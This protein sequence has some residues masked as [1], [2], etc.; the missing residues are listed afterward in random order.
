M[1][2]FASSSAGIGNIFFPVYAGK[3]SGV[4]R[5]VHS[6]HS[7]QDSFSVIRNR[8]NAAGAE[9]LDRTV[10]A[11]IFVFHRP[12][13]RCVSKFLGKKKYGAALA[14]SVLKVSGAEVP[15]QY[16]DSGVDV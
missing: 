12:H 11:G 15:A 1:V 16:P 6:F 3:K 2:V 5:I 4:L 14:G 9:L 10:A 7:D 13:S 8:R